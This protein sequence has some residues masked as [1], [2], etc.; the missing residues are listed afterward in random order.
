METITSTGGTPIAYERTGSGPSLVLVHGATVDHTTWNEALPY[1]AER[2]TVYA[3]DRRGRGGSGD[4]EAY[5]LERETEDVL[6][7]IE[8]IREPVHLLG[9]SYGGVCSLEA[10]LRT[11]R[12]DRLIL[13]EGVMLDAT[14]DE[15]QALVE[16]RQAIETGDREEALVVFYLELAHLTEAEIDYIRDQ[17]TWQRRVEA[18]HTSLREVEA[19]FAYDFEPVR[20]REMTTPTLLL[21]GEDSSESVHQDTQV[22]HE[23]LPESR[24]V[25]LENQQHVAYRMAPEYFADTVTEFLTATP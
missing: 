25:V 7:L 8:S 13:Y 21:V 19:G 12:L 22:L 10:A 4:A 2:F 11:D 24:I 14:T 6:A 18:I 15:E 3:M 9:H 1:L 17:P 20:L 23:A 5:A 16:I